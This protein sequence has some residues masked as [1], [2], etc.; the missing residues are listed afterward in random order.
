MKDVSESSRYRQLTIPYCHG[1]GLDIASGGDPVVPWAINFDLPEPEFSTYRNNAPAFGPIQCR[2]HA[3]NLP[4]DSDSFDFVFSSHLLEDFEDWTPLLKEWV[5]VLKPGGHLV[6]LIPDKELWHQ[7]MLRGQPPN[8]A[9]R[10]EGQV[11]ELSSYAPMLNLTVFED[12]LTNLW[13]GDY[14]IL[15]VALKKL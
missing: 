2:G 7:A 11:G 13:P 10:H 5:R 8:D 3:Q 14:T 9:H 6:L 1:C 4:F 12:R 15:F